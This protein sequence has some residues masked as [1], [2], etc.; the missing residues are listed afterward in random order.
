MENQSPEDRLLG[1]LL[2]EQANP[3]DAKFLRSLESAI[4]ASDSTP[5][6]ERKFPVRAAIA[7]CVLISGTAVWIAFPSEEKRQVAVVSDSRVPEIPGRVQIRPAA[8]KSEKATPLPRRDIPPEISATLGTPPLGTPPIPFPGDHHPLVRL[9][10]LNFSKSV[11]AGEIPAAPGTHWMDARNFT[12]SLPAR[13][14]VTSFE[15]IWEDFLAGRSLSAGIRVEEWVNAMALPPPED[16]IQTEI[17]TWVSP[18]PWNPAH[19]LAGIS[20]KFPN[21]NNAKIAVREISANIEFNPAKVE[22]FR[23]L[24][25]RPAGNATGTSNVPAGTSTFALYELSP[26]PAHAKR[27]RLTAENPEV[28]GEWFAVSLNHR[29]PDE[30]KTVPCS[31][32]L[33]AINDCPAEFRFAT[34]AAISAMKLA[35]NREVSALDWNQIHGLAGAATAH[36]AHI[37]L[38]ALLDKLVGGSQYISSQPAANVPVIPRPGK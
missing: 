22:Q 21:Q 33:L 17:H 23:F 6:R 32:P 5:I 4:R 16:M 2:R 1:E 14:P 3:T 37:Q 25:T 24:G 8:A 27:Y 35:E 19:H 9:R 31:T 34:A 7:A 15:K 12:A 28:A 20:L 38:I 13:L 36:S 26:P 10:D 29:Y 18:C 11:A 30:A